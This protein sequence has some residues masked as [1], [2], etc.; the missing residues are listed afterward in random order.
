M[1][2]HA[3]LKRFLHERLDLF[4]SRIKATGTKDE[5]LSH[6]ISGVM[7]TCRVLD[8]LSKS[9]LE[10]IVNSS[11]Q[12]IFDMSPDERRIAAALEEGGE[13]WD[14]FEKPIHQR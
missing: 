2:D 11:H 12:K 6:Y 1:S 4:Y 3:K 14:F 7:A 9:E 10:E 8:I 13:H 5:P